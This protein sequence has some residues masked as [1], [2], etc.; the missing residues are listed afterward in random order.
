MLSEL[1]PPRFSCDMKTIINIVC[2]IYFML[3]IG[4]FTGYYGLSRHVF[5]VLLFSGLIPFLFTTL[6]LAIKYINKIAGALQ[7]CLS[8][9][10]VRMMGRTG[11]IIIY[12]ICF[13]YLIDA[14]N[15][16][17]IVPWLQ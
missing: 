3:Y 12:L 11:L 4:L 2:H 14:I 16:W 6:W 13:M 9:S 5:G 7:H 15:R 17:G 1:M 10:Q 8:E